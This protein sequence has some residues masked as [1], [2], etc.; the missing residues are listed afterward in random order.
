M[1]QLVSEIGRPRIVIEVGSYMGSST[2]H[3]ASLVHPDG[4]KVY[5]VDWWR[6]LNY[7]Q[8]KPVPGSHQSGYGHSIPDGRD[9]YQQ[10]LSNMIHLGFSKTVMP[11]RAKS[12]EAAVLLKDSGISSANLI[13]IDADHSYTSVLQDCRAWYPFVSSRRGILCGDDWGWSMPALGED[14]ILGVQRAVR[15]FAKEHDLDIFTNGTFWF[16]KEKN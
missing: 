9:M 6:G 14:Y 15:E 16:L 5:A 8:E 10:F 3:L 1:E 7:L 4:G 13:Y 12:Q 2:A 11:V